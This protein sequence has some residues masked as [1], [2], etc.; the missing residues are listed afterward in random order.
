MSKKR[1][2]VDKTLSSR[3]RSQFAKDNKE[4]DEV[5]ERKSSHGDFH[6]KGGKAA[7]TSDG[8]RHKRN[9]PLN[10]DS[11]SARPARGS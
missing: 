6:F 2:E 7:G 9:V 5:Y 11:M 3:I 8:N 1:V 10:K 4:M